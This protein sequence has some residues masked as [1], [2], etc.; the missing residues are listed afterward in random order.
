[1]FRKGSVYASVL[2]TLSST[3]TSD[4]VDSIRT[5]LTQ[6]LA[7]DN[8]LGIDASTFNINCQF[9]YCNSSNTMFRTNR[10]N[11]LKII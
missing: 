6:R 10:S 8:A 5:L 2:L 11:S 4:Q 3:I 9:V 1:M 7:N